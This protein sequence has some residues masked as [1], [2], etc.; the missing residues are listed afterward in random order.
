MKKKFDKSF[1]VIN[2]REVIKKVFLKEDEG[3]PLVIKPNIAGLD[4]NQWYLNNQEYIEKTILKYGG[5]LFRG[6][7][8]KDTDDFY[9]FIKISCPEPLSY[10]EGATPRSQVKGKVYT[11]TEFPNSETIQLHNELSYV[12]TWPKKIWFSCIT[13]AEQGGETPIADVRKV[14][15]KIDSDIRNKFENKGWML[16]RNYGLGFGQT[17]QYVFQTDSKIEVEEYCKHNNMEYNWNC[18][19]TLTTKQIRPAVTRHPDTNEK[20]WFNHIAFWHSSSLKE[21]VKTLMVEEFGENGLPYQT[22]YGDGTPIDEETIRHI[23][24]AYDEFTILFPWQ[25]GDILMLDNMLV[26]HGR[27]PYIGERK[28]LVAMGEPISRKEE[29]L[30]N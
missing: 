22:Y 25:K 28:I 23:Q 10:K 6:F 21:E 13:A 12:M 3:L 16:V 8:I 27:S 29:E 18:D 17:W 9:K 14:Y 20:L 24:K 5:M 4:L 26:A 15:K 11:S 2:Q 7:N 30:I 19:G 1:Q